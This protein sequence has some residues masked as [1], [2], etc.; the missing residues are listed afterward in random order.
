MK[1]ILVWLCWVWNASFHPAKS[2]NLELTNEAWTG[3]SNIACINIWILFAPVYVWMGA[4][5]GWTV[6]TDETRPRTK[7]THFKDLAKEGTGARVMKVRGICYHEKRICFSCSVVS[8]SLW[9]HGLQHARLPYPSPSPWACSNSYPL[10]QWCHPTISS[11][12][13]PFSSCL[14]SFQ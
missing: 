14:Q 12:V 4:L 5:G 9:P 11:S 10:S 1:I 8:D 6:D 13:I 2:M 3:D 7:H